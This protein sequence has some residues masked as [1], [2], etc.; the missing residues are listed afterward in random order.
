MGGAASKRQAGEG[1]YMDLFF[2]L[3]SFFSRV[4]QVAFL[5]NFHRI[6]S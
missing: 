2:P 3:S 6:I 4:R 5:T 1:S